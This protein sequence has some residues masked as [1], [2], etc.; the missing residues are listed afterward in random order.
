MGLPR[1]TLINAET[2]STAVIMN[3]Y[4]EFTSKVARIIRDAINGGTND[5]TIEYDVRQMISFE[6]A[7]AKVQN[8]YSFTCVLVNNQ[9][10]GLIEME[11]YDSSGR[12]TQ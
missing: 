4:S 12:A 11:D 8:K 3:A 5:S 1:S 2:D 10:V 6:I 9:L 7:L